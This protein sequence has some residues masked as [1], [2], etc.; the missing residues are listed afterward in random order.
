MQ[1]PFFAISLMCMDF[2]DMRGQLEFFNRR[3]DYYHVDIMDGHFAPNITLSPD[4]MRS[5]GKVAALPMD[6]HLM[7]TDPDRWIEAVAAAGASIISPHAETINAKAFRTFRR[8]RELGCQTGVVLNP[9][10]PLSDVACYLECIDLL[11]IMT[12]DVGYANQPFIEQMLRKIE[13]ARS[14][15][16]AE[17][18]SFRIQVDG[19]CN[20]ST[21]KRLWDAGAE[22]FVMGSSGLFS[23]DGDIHAAYD[24]MLGGFAQAVGA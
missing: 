4:I 6:A 14:L 17:G 10:T 12:V 18:L 22:V 21:F 15:R 16:E 9:A 5:I 7:T 24:K 19:A 8:I 2:L 20:A 3:A 11:T 13:R 23:L 1:G